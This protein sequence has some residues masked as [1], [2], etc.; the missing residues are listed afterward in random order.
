MIEKIIFFIIQLL[1]EYDIRGIYGVTLFNKD[2]E[3]LGNLFGKIIGTDK[4]IN[5]AFDGRLSS[6]ELKNHLIN[7]FA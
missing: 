2:A 1:E 6:I 4:T 5:V 7:G 3:I